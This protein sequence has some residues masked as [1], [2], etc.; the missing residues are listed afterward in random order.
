MVSRPSNA[1]CT[2]FS[3]CHMYVVQGTMVSRPRNAFLNIF[4]FWAQW[5]LAQVMLF[6]RVCLA[7]LYMFLFSHVCCSGH[8][9]FSPPNAFF[10]HVFCLIRRPPPGGN[11]SPGQTQE[12]ALQRGRGNRTPSLAYYTCFCFL[13]SWAHNG[14]PPVPG[15]P[16]RPDDT[17]ANN[18]IIHVMLGTI[19][20]R[21]SITPGDW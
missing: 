14:M 2:C 16:R 19:V 20:C 21:P 1:F 9:G 6:V 7:F 5:L 8:N 3:F 12:I 17:I 10:V 4:L 13:M 11:T 18:D 15:K